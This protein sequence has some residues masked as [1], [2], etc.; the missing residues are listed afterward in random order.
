MGMDFRQFKS[1]VQTRGITSMAE[2]E[3]RTGISSD[4]I[5]KEFENYP[6]EYEQMQ[7]TMKRN[8]QKA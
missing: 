2:L 1:Y 6:N 3:R 5:K 8:C 4:K 7:N